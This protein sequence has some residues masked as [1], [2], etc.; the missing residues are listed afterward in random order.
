MAKILR[1][2]DSADAL[3]RRLRDRAPVRQAVGSH[4]WAELEAERARLRRRRI[5]LHVACFVGIVITTFLTIKFGA[6]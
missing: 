2:A 3:A 1:L 5:A 6:P 4:G